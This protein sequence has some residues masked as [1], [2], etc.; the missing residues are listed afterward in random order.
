MFRRL[1]AKL[2]SVQLIS[3]FMSCGGGFMGVRGKVVQLCGSIVCALWHGAL[4]YAT[5]E[6]QLLW[7]MWRVRRLRF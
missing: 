1:L 2:V 6:P 3:L 7:A 4:L 5:G